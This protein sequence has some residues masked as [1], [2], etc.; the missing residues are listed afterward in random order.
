MS[1]FV[2]TKEKGFKLKAND[3]WNGDKGPCILHGWHLDSNYNK[4]DDR[5]SISGIM[6]MFNKMVVQAKSK[7][8]PLVMSSVTEAQLVLVVETVQYMMYVQQLLMRMVLKVCLLMI[9]EI[10]N[11]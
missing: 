6:I 7:M 3:T 5:V 9:L 8:Q 2:G 1:F 10:D 11:S 4:Q